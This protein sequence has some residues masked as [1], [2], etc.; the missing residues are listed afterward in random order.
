MKVLLIITILLINLCSFS[1]GV[2]YISNNPNGLGMSVRWGG[3][4]VIYREGITLYKKEN[5]GSWQKINQTKIIPPTTSSS[6]TLTD[7]SLVFYNSF[8]QTS[9][10]EFNSSFTGIFTILESYKDYELAL[11]LNIAYNDKTTTI[12]NTYQYKVEAIHNG[13]TIVLGESNIVEC[14]NYKVINPP[15]KIEIVRKRKKV[16]VKWKNEASK[17]FAYEI[18]FKNIVDENFTIIEKELSAENLLPAK[19]YFLEIPTHKDSSYIFKIKGLDYFGGTGNYSEE[20]PIVI[21]DFDPPSSPVVTIY[22]MA[23]TM[24]VK[25]IW[26]KSLDADVSHYD[27]YKIKDS[28]YIKMNKTPISKN[29]SIY[30][31]NLNGVG[32]VYYKIRAIDFSNNSSLSN[33]VTADIKDIMPPPIPQNFKVIPEVGVFK[34]SWNAVSATD[35]KGYIVYRS[36]AD[37]NNDDNRYVAVTKSID[38]TYFEEPI[39]KNVRAP[40]V[41]IV[42]SLDTLF[43]LSPMSSQ[44]IAQLPDVTPPVKPFIQFSNEITDGIKLEW[45]KNREADLKGYNLFRK[46]LNDTMAFEQV[47]INLI[48]KSNTTYTDYRVKRGIMYEYYIQAIDFSKLASENSNIAKIKFNF[49]PLSGAINIDKQKFNKFKQEIN[50]EWNADSLFNENILG[51]AVYRQNQDSVFIKVQ[52]VKSQQKFKEKLSRDGLYSYQI[53]AYGERGNIVKSKNIAIKVII[54]E[55]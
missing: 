39:S 9:K 33:T 16:L 7:G 40:F 20:K 25:L 37:D 54:K 30:I 6:I 27:V 23:K 28:T 14:E 48:P 2:V 19:N 22:P 38:T 26:T 42:K 17:Y 15:S 55:F 8:L 50:I 13:K 32:M 44:V 46:K 41:Y 3:P 43:N 24:Q 18:A 10:E 53:R 51:Y 34:M 31:D 45:Q 35:F 12:G 52:K 4:E 36:L 49:L 47:N 11:A 1:Q 29:D 21:E 5:K